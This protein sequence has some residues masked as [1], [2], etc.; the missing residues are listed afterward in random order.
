MKKYMFRKSRNIFFHIIYMK[1]VG[2][3]YIYAMLWFLPHSYEMKRRSMNICSP[4]SYDLTH[5]SEDEK[6]VICYTT[7]RVHI[8]AIYILRNIYV[9]S[10][11]C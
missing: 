10:I 9:M 2:S 6:I 11:Y 5:I 3:V 4:S 1:D 7:K 8:Y